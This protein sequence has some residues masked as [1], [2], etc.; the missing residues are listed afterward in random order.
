MMLKPVIVRPTLPSLAICSL[1]WPERSE[2][3]VH[4]NTAVAS[5]RLASAGTHFITSVRRWWVHITP[6]I[7]WTPLSLQAAIILRTCPTSAASGF[8]HLRNAHHAH[9]MVSRFCRARVRALSRTER[10]SCAGR[11]QWSGTRGDGWVWGCRRRPP[12]DHA[13][14]PHS[15]RRPARCPVP[16][17]TLP[18]IFF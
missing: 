18:H 14:A 15:C 1:H 17:P 8:S 7:S 4:F 9:V 5:V 10:A 11:R 16:S 6:S 12:P 13:A 3:A 2:P